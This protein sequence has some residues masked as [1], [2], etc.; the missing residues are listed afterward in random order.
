M[1]RIFHELKRQWGWLLAFGLPM[2]STGCYASGGYYVE[3]AGVYVGPRYYRPIRDRCAFV[4]WCPSGTQ[5]CCFDV[6]GAPT[7][8]VP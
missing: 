6:N 5:R 1:K 4:D 2:C 7:R 3:P 8:V